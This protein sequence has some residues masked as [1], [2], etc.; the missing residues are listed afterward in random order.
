MTDE[1]RAELLAVPSSDTAAQ[2]QQYIETK[3]AEADSI[4][5]GNTRVVEEHKCVPQPL[6]ALCLL[7]LA[8][9]AARPCAASLAS[10]SAQQYFSYRE[11]TILLPLLCPLGPL[12]LTGLA[13]T[14]TAPSQA[15]VLEDC[16]DREQ[17]EGTEAGA[18]RGSGGH[19]KP[20]GA[21]CSERVADRGLPMARV[22]V[23]GAVH[24]HANIFLCMQC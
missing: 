7:R 17:A 5:C 21:Q 9:L 20:P 10:V 14:Q 15:A 16:A 23:R 13:I 12:F 18:R 22:N 3:Q 11:A 4:V 6:L 24:S 1:L 8:H 19:C 2:L